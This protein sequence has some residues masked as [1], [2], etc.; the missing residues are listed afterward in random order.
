MLVHRRQRVWIREKGFT[1]S[2]SPLGL[3]LCGGSWEWQALER[4]SLAMV[5]SSSFCTSFQFPLPKMVEKLPLC[6][7]WCAPQKIHVFPG[8]QNMALFGNRI[9]ADKTVM[10]WLTGGRVGSKSGDSCPYK[11]AVWRSDRDW[12][13]TP[14]T[15][16]CQQSQATTSEQGGHGRDSP[17]GPA[18]G[19]AY[20]ACK[21]RFLA[22]SLCRGKVL[23]F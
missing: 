4:S 8:T 13:D 10:M 19:H 12:K 1:F 7:E 5:V 9:F 6:I 3:L 14:L 15:K 23:L 20:W 18:G 21:L 2:F 22:F 17:S 16:K 11:Q